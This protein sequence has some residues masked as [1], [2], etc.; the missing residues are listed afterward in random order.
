MSM[1]KVLCCE[2]CPLYVRVNG[3]IEGECRHPDQVI[4]PRLVKF[5]HINHMTTPKWCP[6]RKERH[7]LVLV[8]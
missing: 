4:T 6:L 1:S 5:K 3:R 2:V 8:S 7:E